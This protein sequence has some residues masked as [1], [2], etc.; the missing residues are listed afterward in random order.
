MTVIDTR[1]SAKEAE[2]AMW[3][4]ASLVDESDVESQYLD[5][6]H[7]VMRLRAK[8][9]TDNQIREEGRALEDLVAK[10]ILPPEL[11]AIQIEAL[12]EAVERTTWIECY[13]EDS[14][15]L[16]GP[17]GLNEALK[18]IRSLAA[19]LEQRDV[20]ILQLAYGEYG[21]Q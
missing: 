16:S 1:L 15:G 9:F 6:D 5:N 21:F 3:I 4:A 11:N 8:G 18:A 19:K 12:K 13:A 10:R 14:L 2:A 7:L 17:E 20:E